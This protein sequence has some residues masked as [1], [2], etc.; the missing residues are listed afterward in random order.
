MANTR[1]CPL[2][3]YQYVN[4]LNAFIDGH[5]PYCPFSKELSPTCE[6]E[7]PGKMP[8]DKCCARIFPNLSLIK[9]I[10]SL[11]ADIKTLQIYPKGDIQLDGS[12]PKKSFVDWYC[13]VKIDIEKKES[14]ISNNSPISAFQG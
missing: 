4:T 9:S 12:T 14:T 11:G 7:I 2:Y 5:G 1:D 6:M 10:E 8:R 13:G 3:E